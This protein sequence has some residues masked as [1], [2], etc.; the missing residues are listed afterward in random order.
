MAKL[1]QLCKVKK[2]KKKKLGENIPGEGQDE[3]AKMVPRPDVCGTQC[4]GD[5]SGVEWSDKGTPLYVIRSDT[6]GKSLGS[7]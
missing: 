7:Q 4:L 5:N 2:K 6:P 1:I 3:D